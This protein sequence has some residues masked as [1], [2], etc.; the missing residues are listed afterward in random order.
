LRQAP[1]RDAAEDARM[2]SVGAEG[3]RIGKT[4]IFHNEVQ[5]GRI[6]LILVPEV[7]GF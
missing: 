6:V 2:K 3:T 5:V 4:M 7:L 1:V